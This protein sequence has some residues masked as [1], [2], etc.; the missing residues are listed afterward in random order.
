MALKLFCD[1]CD[2]EIKERGIKIGRGAGM[3]CKKCWMDKKNWKV[4]HEQALKNS[5]Y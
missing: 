5:K 1:F 3:Y 4:I 2:K